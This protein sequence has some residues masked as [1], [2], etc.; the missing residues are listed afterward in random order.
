MTR[1]TLGVLSAIALALSVAVV[2]DRP[3][4]EPPAAVSDRVIPGFEAARV[5]R[6]AIHGGGSPGV[7]LARGEGGALELVE[8]SRAPTD[9]GAVDDLLGTLEYLAWRRRVP[10]GDA[11]ARGFDPPAC[12]LEIELD[13][14]RRIELAIG[15]TERAQGRTWL[16]SSATPGEVFL[17]EEYQARALDRRPEDLRR[18]RPFSLEP[19]PL[20]ALEIETRGGR[21]IVRGNCLEVA[22]GCARPDPERLA[23]AGE[24]LGGIVYTRFVDEA[25]GKSAPPGKPGQ[26]DE[27]DV[28]VRIVVG[29]ATL[30]I[31]G[32]CPGKKGELLARSAI[33]TGCVPEEVEAELRELAGDPLDWVDRALVPPSAVDEKTIVVSEPG[34]RRV[35]LVRSGDAWQP[36]EGPV[37]LDAR[38][39]LRVDAAALAREVASDEVD[40][41]LREL[42]AVRAREV[43]LAPRDRRLVA[44]IAVGGV[45]VAFDGTLAWRAEEPVALR[46]PR[47]AARF[48]RADPIQFAERDLL[49]F[50][51]WALTAVELE[52]DDGLERAVRGRAADDWRLTVPYALP[53]DIDAVLALRDTAARLRAAE[54][55][56]ATSEPHHR[57][58]PPRRRLTFTVDPPPGEPTAEPARYGLELGA[59]VEA[60][61]YARRGGSATVYRL[62][63]ATCEALDAHLATRELLGEAE[64]VQAVQIGGLRFVREG[65]RWSRPTVGAVTPAEE[66]ALE[67]LLAALREAPEAKGYGVLRPRARLVV[68][69]A[70]GTMTIGFASPELAIEGRPVRYRIPEAACAAWPTLCR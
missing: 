23:R 57:L 27:T 1:R 50:D 53:A 47:E 38:G 32:A 4:R 68:E 58:D 13:D 37:E 21:V 34:G 55:I 18:R 67:G 26:A 22:G 36:T 45:T 70:S 19:G 15:R 14:G 69:R 61:C 25:G 2:I 20:E 62:S 33:G 16:T 49:S 28:R 40:A 48:F 24:R 52:G 35:Q 66:R 44:S 10:A 12:R 30:W 29:R 54:V 60:G 31:G 43:V 64:D 9:E 17:V 51:P 41:W 5:L 3:P 65:G 42:A 6:I 11:A 56:A 7:V 46:L 39:G 8:P 63:E 59:R